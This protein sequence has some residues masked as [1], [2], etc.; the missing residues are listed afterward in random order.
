[1]ADFSE[2]YRGPKDP[3]LCPLCGLHLDNQSNSFQC[4]IVKEKTKV[5]G[6]YLQIF[7]TNIPAQLFQLLE[8][9]TEIRKNIEK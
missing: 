8:L 2:N 9:I 5:T 3:Q 6:E 4:Y 7:Q 1:M